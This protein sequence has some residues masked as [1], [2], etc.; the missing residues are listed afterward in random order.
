ML[1]SWTD[2][3]VAWTFATV[4]IGVTLLIIS[5]IAKKIAIQIDELKEELRKNE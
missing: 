1:T 2:A 3:I 5:V 4:I